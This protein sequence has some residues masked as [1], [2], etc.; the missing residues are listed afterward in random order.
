M[1]E[2]SSCGKLVLCGEYA[3]LKG[4]TGISL[5]VNKFNHLTYTKSDELIW[6]VNGQNLDNNWVKNIKK[7]FNFDIEWTQI[8]GWG[9]S[10]STI[11]NLCKVFDLDPIDCYKEGSGIDFWT[12]YKNSSLLYNKKESINLDIQWNFTDQIYFLPLNKKVSSPTFTLNDFPVNEINDLTSLIANCRNIE[13]FL[14]Y[15]KE[16]DKI[17]SQ[18]IEIKPLQMKHCS[19]VKYLGTWGGDTVMLIGDDLHKYYPSAINYSKLIKN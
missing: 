4:A 7:E 10:G 12:S 11:A 17:V 14:N 1:K 2:V 18:I 6:Q 9:S 15:L 13:S 5:A 16:H 8:N 3:L 19:Y